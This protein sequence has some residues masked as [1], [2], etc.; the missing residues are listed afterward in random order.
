MNAGQPGST[1]G[2]S[3]DATPGGPDA[4]LEDLVLT[5]AQV[6]QL[7]HMSTRR[8]HILVQSGHLKAHKIPGTRQYLFWRHELIDLINASVVDPADA[9]DHNDDRDDGGAPADQGRRMTKPT[10]ARGTT[11]TRP[12]PSS[13]T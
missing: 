9:D 1:S 10:P 8:V 5:S 2:P 12:R 7:L 13:T 11:R 6:A 4:R 3:H